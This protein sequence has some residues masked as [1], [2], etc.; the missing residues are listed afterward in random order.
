VKVAVASHVLVVDDDAALGKV[1]TALLSQAGLGADHVSSGREA[2]VQL[3][4]RP[5]DL[6][7]TDL[8]MPG[9]DGMALLLE[10]AR[11]WPDVPVIML[12]A[13]GNVPLAVEA[14]KAGAAE[15]MLKPFDREE[16]VFVV[17][18][19]LAGAER[20]NKGTPSLPKSTKLFGD[21]AAMREVMDLVRRA[22]PGNATVLLLGES[23]TGKELVAHAIHEASPR[24]GKPFV[25]LNCGA[26]PD[27]LLESELFGYE[28]GA[29]TGAATRKPGRI[30]LAHEGTLL[31]DE[32]GDITLPMQVK[33]LRVLQERE[34]ERLGG[35]TTIQ[36][37]VRFVAATHRNL[38]EM[39]AKGLFREDLFYRLNVVPIHLPPL[40][41]R[42]ED[43][44]P[45]ARQFTAEHARA[46]A[47]EIELGADAL[48][49]LSGEAWPGNV[50]QLQNFIERLVVLCDG[51]TI[52]A[53][54][55]LRELARVEPGL[56]PSSQPE[57]GGGLDATRKVAE[58][59]AIRTALTRAGGN[60]TVAARI[61]G[62]SRRGLY[63][64]LDEHGLA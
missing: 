7:L 51:P 14:M 16:L 60:R 30:E 55:V 57:G 26:L 54:E 18:K 38:P 46:N 23:G 52:S 32:I 27:A 12:T 50:R 49:L 33:L 35:T 17:Q 4:K 3:E 53:R 21:S 19:V 63:Y 64:K 48:Q 2:L 13:H 22:A 47:K 59:E 36:I 1:L 62:L 28:K 56:G 10:L 11:R 43:I 45:L 41:S 8:R 9:M 61:L 40:R 6:V 42:P 24:S 15:F 29:F 31:L 20:A 44:Q 37:D 39:V 58:K 34:V 25:K 5:Y